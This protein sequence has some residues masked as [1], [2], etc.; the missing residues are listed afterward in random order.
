VGTQE[1]AGLSGHDD[2]LD[3]VADGARRLGATLRR[4]V[5]AAASYLLVNTGPGTRSDVAE[6]FVPASTIPLA[7]AFT[8]HDGRTGTELPFHAEVF[9]PEDEPTRP[10]GR[11]VRVVVQDVP[12][13]GWV[14]LDL[15]PGGTMPE[16]QRLT[17]PT[18]IENEYFRV[19]YDLDDAVIRSVFDKQ[20][21]RELVDTESPA[22]FGQYIYDRYS[23]APHVNH[24]SGHIE[25][26]PGDLAL[27]A[28]RTLGRRAS[29]VH[30]EKTAISESLTIQTD[31]DGV[32]WIRTTLRV[33]KGVRRVEITQRIAKRGAPA[34]E[35]VYFAFP[36]AMGET[37]EPVWEL[38]GGVGGARVPVVPGAARHMRPIRHWIGFGDDDYAV[39]WATLEAPLVMLGDLYLPYA[40]FP[41]TVE[42]DRPEPATVYSWALNNIWD[43]N[44]PAQQQGETVFRYAIGSGRDLGPRALG[45]RTAAGLTDPFVAV[46]LA[47][48]DAEVAGVT[49]GTGITGITEPAGVFV[50]TDHDHVHVSSLG[51]SRRGDGLV[52]YLRSIADHDA[53][54]EVTLPVTPS[55]A[56]LGTSLERELVAVPVTDDRVR[57]TVPAGAFVALVFSGV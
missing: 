15:R 27:L 14:R 43:T 17:D 52:A 39:A 36:F 55:V 57:V 45:A 34:K 12:A 56:F 54:V 23:T 47:A 42:P 50:A 32:D 26:V 3:L 33:H 41:A 49:A 28:S 6:F 13:I 1:R 2:A 46:P 40:P 25:A 44:F 35:S 51:R 30:S 22:G 9:E 7:E 37:A 24:L 29:V 16:A 38:T 11:R 21:G 10:S 53:E 20:A 18:Q 19:E 5:T 48:P 4:P 31:G 8:V